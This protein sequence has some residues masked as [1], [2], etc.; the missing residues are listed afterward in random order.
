MTR[1]IGLA[2]YL[3]LAEQITGIEAAVGRSSLVRRRHGSVSSSEPCR[4]RH[5]TARTTGIR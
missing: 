2:E 4:V 5:P 3:W 1:Y